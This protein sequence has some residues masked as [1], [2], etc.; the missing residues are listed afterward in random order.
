MSVTI[1]IP[2]ITAD[3]C[4]PITPPQIIIPNNDC[5]V[6]GSGVI[7]TFDPSDFSVIA[8][9]V[10]LVTQSGLTA[11]TYNS[12][13]VNSKGIVTAASTAAFTVTTAAPI[14]GD[15]SG[16]SPIT[17]AQASGSVN[18]YLSSTDWNTFNN[19]VSTVRTISTTSPLTGGGDLSAN[20]TISIPQ[21]TSSVN[22]YLSSTD[23]T[24][25]NN[26]FTNSM[27]TSK[28][29]GRYSPLT[30]I[31]EEI[32]IGA[33]VTLSAGGTLSATGSG[34]TVTSIATGTGLTGGTITT[35][36]TLSV[37]T[38]GITDALLRQSSGLSII[39]RSA[40]ST[41][42]VA[43]ITAANDGEVLR[44]SGATIGFGTIATAGI[45]NNAV[46]YAK[47]QQASTVTLLG[48]PTGG[49]ANVSEITLG[50]SLTFSGTTINTIQGLRTAD[51]PSFTGLTVS[52]LT[53]GRVI[54]TGTGGLLSTSANLLWTNASNQ[55]SINA[56]PTAAY[57]LT[58]NSSIDIKSGQLNVTDTGTGFAIVSAAK[59]LRIR[60]GA[61][62]ATRFATDQTIRQGANILSMT[63]PSGM[64]ILNENSY[65]AYNASATATG[66]EFAGYKSRGTISV[67]T[68]TQ[69]GDVL[70]IFGGRGYQTTSN[71]FST[72]SVGRIE[73]RAAE[74]FTSTAQGTRVGVLVTPTGSTTAAEVATFSS[75]DA[76]AYLTI[77]AG[78]TARPQLKLTSGTL[79]TTPYDGNLE[80]NGTNLSLSVSSTR[81][82]LLKAL[83]GSATLD[84]GSTAAGTSTDLTIT[85]TGAADGDEVI[86]GVPNVST[87]A[88]GV[89]SAWVSAANTVTVRFSNNSLV[90]A[91]DP[92][93][94]T[95]KV[96]VIKR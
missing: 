54:Y 4:P 78:T 52:G 62:E 56:S 38:N 8:N 17:I 37:A 16:G 96:S 84:F 26:K 11:G 22:G 85:V 34:G 77:A 42:N 89:F 15:G 73:V 65:M 28:L 57:D 21:A 70:C 43:D 88:N 76:E 95:F 46:T 18:G 9:N 40:N 61:T 5:S 3:N 55:L 94:G 7:Y 1:N 71:A 69:S 29:L 48:N 31:V 14:T 10:S 2:T 92:A 67:P 91:Y 66:N 68:A 90:T 41:G 36:G 39:G 35:S 23:W 64:T 6:G 63:A 20:R 44:R 33:G 12:V 13:T 82:T 51:S 58:V 32:T 30:G 25:F 72:T 86:L 81:Y 19:K 80:Y 53:A 50:T 27:N 47:I 60:A 49:T 83:T 45:A 59:P 79:T 74:A 75:T 24:T 87:V 93:S